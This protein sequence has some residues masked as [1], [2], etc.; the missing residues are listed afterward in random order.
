LTKFGIFAI[1]EYIK[2]L[3]TVNTTYMPQITDATGPDGGEE[4]SN[5]DDE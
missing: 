3:P 5:T 4:A 1:K 2:K